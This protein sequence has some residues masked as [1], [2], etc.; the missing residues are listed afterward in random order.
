MELLKNKRYIAYCFGT[1]A[2]NLGLLT[3]LS[4]TPE[5]TRTLL[6]HNGIKDD[7][8]SSSMLTAYGLT[9]CLFR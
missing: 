1:M 6:R 4:H 7:Y 5:L 3:F 9:S 2:S 8:I